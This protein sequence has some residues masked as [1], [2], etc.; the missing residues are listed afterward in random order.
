VKYD[1]CAICAMLV[2]SVFRLTRIL[3]VCVCPLKAALIC[4]GIL[5]LDGGDLNSQ[6]LRNVGGALTLSTTSTL[7][8]GSGMGTSSVLAGAI[9]CALGNLLDVY[10]FK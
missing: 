2:C 5:S 7:P 6:L 10:I 4:A 8:H 1:M 9:L 3:C